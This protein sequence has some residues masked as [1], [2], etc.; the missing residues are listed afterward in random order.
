LPTER[1]RSRWDRV[2]ATGPHV[3]PPVLKH[4]GRTVSIVPVG[5]AF[6]TVGEYHEHSA[7][8]NASPEEA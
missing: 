2:L 8:Q 1:T 3:L 7:G 4:G 6:G 5:A